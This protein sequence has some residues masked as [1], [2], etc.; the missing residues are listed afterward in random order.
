MQLKIEISTVLILTIALLANWTQTF[1][2]SFTTCAN[3]NA[4]NNPI[5]T[6]PIYKDL[7]RVL[8]WNIG[9]HTLLH[10]MNKEHNLTMQCLMYSGFN[11]ENLMR[12]TGENY[13]KV[14]EIF[15]A[16]FFKIRVK[17]LGQIMQM[18]KAEGLE[19][20]GYEE[21]TEIVRNEIHDDLDKG[22][23]PELSVNRLQLR[24]DH[25]ELDSGINFVSVQ[26]KIAQSYTIYVSLK[27]LMKAYAL[28]TIRCVQEYLEL[29][30]IETPP[31]KNYKMYDQGRL[32]S[33]FPDE[34]VQ[35]VF[36][37]QKQI[38]KQLKKLAEE[39]TKS[40]QENLAKQGKFKNLLALHL[41]SGSIKPKDIEPGVTPEKM[42]TKL[43]IDPKPEPENAE[44]EYSEDQNSERI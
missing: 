7:V 2:M 9:Q 35:R 44:E 1:S 15:M 23:D 16:E 10:E 6:E 26:Q 30:D 39:S 12:C 32:D 24:L 38:H 34:E 3:L 21:E 33:V 25:Q 4:T 43:V 14:I 27:R 13:D 22:R 29:I 41:A 18:L 17:Y 31:G 42:F 19:Q 20:K 37:E 11:W 36:Q 5:I 8:E 40:F 28:M